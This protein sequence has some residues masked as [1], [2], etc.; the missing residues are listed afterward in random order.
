[1]N[2]LKI[3]LAIVFIVSVVMFIV[4][5]LNEDLMEAVTWGVIALLNQNAANSLDN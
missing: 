5:F 2:W 1:M 4:S 3:C